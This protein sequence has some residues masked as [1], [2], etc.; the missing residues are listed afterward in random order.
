MKS[1]RKRSHANVLKKLPAIETLLRDVKDDL[2]PDGIFLDAYQ[3]VLDALHMV[4]RARDI[5]EKHA[6]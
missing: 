2:L 5:Y 3:A 6:P 4:Q 1:I